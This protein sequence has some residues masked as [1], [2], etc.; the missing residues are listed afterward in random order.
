MTVLGLIGLAGFWVLAAEFGGLPNFAW[1]TPYKLSDMDRNILL[2]TDA[3]LQLLQAKYSKEA[4]PIAR[5]Q[6]DVLSRVCK[7]AKLT[8]G[9][10]CIVDASSSTVSKKPPASPTPAPAKK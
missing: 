9:L 4:E 8:V 10:D 2:R 3:Q 5:E 7:A 6:Q 1:S